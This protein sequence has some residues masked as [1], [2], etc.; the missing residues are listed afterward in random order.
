VGEVT[1]SRGLPWSAG[2]VSALPGAV[3]RLRPVGAGGAVGPPGGGR[4]GTPPAGGPADEVER[5]RRGVRGRVGGQQQRR[6]RRL[7]EVEVLHYVPE[8]RQG[9]PGGGAPRG[10]PPGAWGWSGPP[11]GGGPL[12]NYGRG[13]SLR[14][15]GS[16][17]PL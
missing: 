10:A 8:G 4:R 14:L 13:P 15:G 17:V 6:A 7:V 5:D 9:P 16:V 12:W 2:G 3:V 1:C 11:P